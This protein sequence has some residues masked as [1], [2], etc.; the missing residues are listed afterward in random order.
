MDSPRNRM[1]RKV[2]ALLV[3]GFVGYTAV[4]LTDHHLLRVSLIEVRE[5]TDT[6]LLYKPPAL[7]PP[8]FRFERPDLLVALGSP[9]PPSV[10]AS[11]GDMG[12]VIH[13]LELF[14]NYFGAD[15]VKF[16][17]I[18]ESPADIIRQL[19][20]NRCRG[21]CSNDV[22]SFVAMIQKEGYFARHVIM[23]ANDGLG[24][25]GHSVAEIWLPDQGRW[26]MVDV[27]NVAHVTDSTGRTL[28]VAELREH[29]LRTRGDNLTVLQHDRGYLQ[30][31][32]NGRLLRFFQDR[33]RD[34]HYITGNGL[35]TANET[36]L[37]RRGV[38]AAEQLV[39][40]LG[41]RAMNLPR[42]VGRILQ[43]SVRY[44]LMD[45]L[46]AATYNPQAWLS[47]YRV[48]LG[49]FLAGITTLSGHWLIRRYRK[50]RGT[51]V[52]ADE[53]T[54]VPRSERV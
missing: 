31:A 10:T 48:L 20:V 18:T 41:Y 17:P 5:T 29:L 44:R 42:F 26:I 1:T 27:Q 34:V 25:S 46:N 45:D 2:A 54:Y 40:P 9:L 23:A 14:G 32:A 28:S 43:T 4:L 47:F 22:I 35:F 53:S 7:L 24:G 30:P 11:G 50:Q 36:S 37:V 3:A 52:K 15:G 19:A 13:A 6:A 51:T 39:S 12:R 33:I 21:F 8:V 49:L 16:C 38:S